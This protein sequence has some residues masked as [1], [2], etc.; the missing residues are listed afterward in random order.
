MVPPCPFV[1]HSVIF[2]FSGTDTPTETNSPRGAFL[3]STLRARF[4]VRPHILGPREKHRS[5]RV[6]VSRWGVSPGAL[7]GVSAI[8][9]RQHVWPAHPPSSGQ[10]G[11]D[12][13]PDARTGSLAVT[14]QCQTCSVPDMFCRPSRP[15]RWLP[16]HGRWVGARTSRAFLHHDGRT[17]SLSIRS[18]PRSSPTGLTVA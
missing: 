2:S 13:L 9:G 11:A 14:D 10:D 6:G 8:R 1:I 3:Y 12:P 17:V 7:L 15:C 5:E 18:A 4:V 16:V